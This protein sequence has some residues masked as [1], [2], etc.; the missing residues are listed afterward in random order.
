MNEITKEKDTCSKKRYHQAINCEQ[1]DVEFG[2]TKKKVPSEYFE[3]HEDN[4]DNK[5]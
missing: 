5:E 2:L 3:E 4:E 1:V